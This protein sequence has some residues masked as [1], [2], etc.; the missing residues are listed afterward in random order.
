MT[1][2][3]TTSDFSDRNPSGDKNKSGLILFSTLGSD[4]S[5]QTCHSIGCLAGGR[6]TIGVTLLAKTKSVSKDL[7]KRKKNSCSGCDWVISFSVS[8]VKRP[9]PSSL[10]FKSNRVLTAIRTVAM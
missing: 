7:S 4:N 2:K 8:Y 9:R 10:S 1:G 3:L 5:N 6:T